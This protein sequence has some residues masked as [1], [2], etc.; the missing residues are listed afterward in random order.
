MPSRSQRHV[1]YT[2]CADSTGSSRYPGAS[3]TWDWA[4]T[5]PS[6]S[7]QGVAPPLV[8]FEDEAEEDE[9]E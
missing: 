6:G 9:D 7:G 4:N 8:A 3:Y 1:R 5:W 2:M